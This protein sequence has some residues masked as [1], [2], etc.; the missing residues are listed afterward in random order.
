MLKA[1]SIRMS[2]IPVCSS[3]EDLDYC[4]FCPG[5]AYMEAGDM[6]SPYPRACQESRINR[7]IRELN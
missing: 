1:R 4:K 7:K 5:L 3:C 2:E 6:E